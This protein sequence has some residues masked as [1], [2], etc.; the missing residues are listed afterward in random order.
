MIAAK[1][2]DVRV[3]L[4]TREPQEAKA[5]QAVAVAYLEAFWRS[6]RDGPERLT[7]RRFW[8]LLAKSTAPSLI[9]LRM[10]L[11]Q[12]RSGFRLRLG[13]LRPSLGSS[14]VTL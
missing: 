12:R 6:M 7:Q 10:I 4:R 3:S 13:N 1:D 9:P 14:D 2:V 5:R 8:P 11:A